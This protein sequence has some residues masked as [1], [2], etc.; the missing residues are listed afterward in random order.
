MFYVSVGKT[1]NNISLQHLSKNMQFM[2]FL[3]RQVMFTVSQKMSMMLHTITS[4]HINWF[5]Q[6]LAEMLLTESAVE[7]WFVIPYAPLN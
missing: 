3:F 7:W 4:L 1:I 5:W 2:C 6:F